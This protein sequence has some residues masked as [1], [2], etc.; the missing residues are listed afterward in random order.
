MKLAWLGGH[1]AREVI[2]VA[3][4]TRSPIVRRLR[5]R[6]QRARQRLGEITHHCSRSDESGRRGASFDPGFERRQDIVVGVGTS[7]TAS[8]SEIIRADAARTMRHARNQE[9]AIELHRVWRSRA[10]HPETG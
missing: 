8:I 1:R 3:R 9:Q 6:A 4:V 2:G 5:I 10:G 7:R